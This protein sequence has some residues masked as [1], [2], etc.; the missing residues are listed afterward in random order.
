MDGNAMV[1]HAFQQLTD[2]RNYTNFKK[3]ILFF[4]CI[5]F[6]HIRSKKQGR[7]GGLE[8]TV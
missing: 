8:L 3:P 7:V 1:A 6:F 5:W 4:K 2:Y